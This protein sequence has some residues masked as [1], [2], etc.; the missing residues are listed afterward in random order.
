MRLPFFIRVHP[1]GFFLKLRG[2]GVLLPALR[3]ESTVY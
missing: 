1:Y 2:G 3:G